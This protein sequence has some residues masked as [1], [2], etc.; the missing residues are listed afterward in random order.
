MVNRTVHHKLQFMG[1]N[2]KCRKIIEKAIYFINTYIFQIQIF[3]VLNQ[4]FLLHCLFCCCCCSIFDTNCLPLL[5]IF[6]KTYF[7]WSASILITFNQTLNKN[8]NK[9]SLENIPKASLMYQGLKPVYYFMTISNKLSFSP[10]KQWIRMGKP[11][12][13]TVNQVD[14]T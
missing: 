12:Y 8:L 3:K 11:L 2:K 4:I 14:F 7:A 5:N 13:P 10:H 1:L 6:Q 9:I